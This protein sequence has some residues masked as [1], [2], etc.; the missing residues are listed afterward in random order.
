MKSDRLCLFSVAMFVAVLCSGCQPSAK[1]K[2]VG[3]WQGTIEFDDAKVQQKLDES[4]NNP[5]KQTIAKAFINAVK[6]GTMDIELK[7]DDSFTS[8]I[9]LGPLS[10]DTFG[11]WTVITD[12]GKRVTVQLTNHDGKIDQPTLIFSDNETFTVEAHGEAAEFAVFR[13]RRVTTAGD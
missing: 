13:C 1:D 7:A 5:L 3:H 8:S 11:K 12:A 2:L 9:K 10:K 6:K 4:G